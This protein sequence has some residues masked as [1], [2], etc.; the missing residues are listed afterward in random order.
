MSQNT[1]EAIDD[2]LI[3][4]YVMGKL[5]DGEVSTHLQTC[6]LCARRVAETHEYV[7]LIQQGLQAFAGR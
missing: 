1:C 2:H 6:A 4:L 7:L 3:E 5:D